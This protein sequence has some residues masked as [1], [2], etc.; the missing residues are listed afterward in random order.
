M[1]VKSFKEVGSVIV[2]QAGEGVL[3]DLDTFESMEYSEVIE[4]IEYDQ[5]GRYMV[6]DVHGSMEYFYPAEIEMAA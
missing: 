5:Y 6:T 3:I 2:G 1:S 4:S